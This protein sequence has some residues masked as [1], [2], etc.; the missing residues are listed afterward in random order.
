MLQVALRT[1][2]LLAEGLKRLHEHASLCEASLWRAHGDAADPRPTVPRCE[3]RLVTPSARKVTLRLASQRLA[4]SWRRFRPSANSA[5]VRSATC[6]TFSSQDHAEAGFAMT[7]V[8][9]E[10]LQTLGQQCHGAKRD[11]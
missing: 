6:N 7:G 10:T 4:C 3:A 9:M 8:L 5:T 2:A 11:L 1:V